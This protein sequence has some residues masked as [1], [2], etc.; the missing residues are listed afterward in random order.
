MIYDSINNF[1]DYF[2]L[3]PHFRTAYDFMKKNDPSSMAEGKC[4]VN[5]NGIFALISE[6]NTKV[7][8]EAFIEC[9]RKYIDI[10]ILL[11][12]REKIGVCNIQDCREYPYD[13]E[14]D[15]QKLA[16]EVSLINMIPGRFVIFFPRDGH[17]PQI[18]YGD[19]PE[20]VKKVVFK[21]PVEGFA[22]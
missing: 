10:Q 3:H 21:V 13:S 19:F 5:N 7:I 20:K 22:S 8:S 11:E 6:Y 1:T 4:E 9:H 17:M 16:G 15:L 2:S 14:K 18:Q 12:G